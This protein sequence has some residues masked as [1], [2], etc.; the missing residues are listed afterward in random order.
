M[1][2]SRP[3]C[4][5][6]A[7]C[8]VLSVSLS[9]VLS[10]YPVYLLRTPCSLSPSLSR[11][12][13]LPPSLLVTLWSF[14]AMECSSLNDIDLLNC[15][16]AAVTLNCAHSTFHESQARCGAM[17][18][19]LELTI[20]DAVSTQRPMPQNPCSALPARERFFDPAHTPKICRSL[21]HAA[22]SWVPA[23]T[24]LQRLP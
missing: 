14:F 3:T 9:V 19:F 15:T 4:S 11:I 23:P 5:L 20:R 22:R 24:G 16:L 17:P 12:L 1:P 10:P 13:T 6:S 21:A 7:P 2:S 8:V 18:E